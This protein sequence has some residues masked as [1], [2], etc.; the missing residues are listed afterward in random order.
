MLRMTAPSDAA[1]GSTAPPRIPD[2]TTFG[3]RLAL[4]RQHMGWGNVAEAARACGLDRES[5]RKWEQTDRTPHRYITICIAIA[6]AA[7]V[8]LDWLIRGSKK[9]GEQ[10]T[11]GYPWS[12]A[13]LVNPPVP[14]A[15]QPRVIAQIG[16]GDRRRTSGRAGRLIPAQ[17]KVH[18]GRPVSRQPVA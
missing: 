9:S 6:T 2:D 1:P 18:N 8:D 11:L 10:L 5:W 16:H 12:P 3:A 14:A 15:L 4:V 17:A 7:N 13:D